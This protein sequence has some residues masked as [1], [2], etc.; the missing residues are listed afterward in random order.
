[1]QVVINEQKYQLAEKTTVA[2]AL[3]QLKMVEHGLAVA[4]NY[5]VIP[6]QDW[7]EHVLVDG[8]VVMLVTATQGG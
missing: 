1:M 6:R 8:D 3:N 5:T 4:V 2:E 7:P